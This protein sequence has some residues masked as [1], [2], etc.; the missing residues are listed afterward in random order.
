MKKKRTLYNGKH[1]RTLALNGVAHSKKMTNSNSV[2][3]LPVDSYFSSPV[4]YFGEITN[5][6]FLF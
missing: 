4:D 6:Y 2:D 3:L 5:I 1:K